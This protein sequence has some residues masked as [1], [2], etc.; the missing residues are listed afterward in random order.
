MEIDSIFISVVWIKAEFGG[1]SH[2][3]IIG[4]RPIIRFQHYVEDWLSIAKD[5]EVVELHLDKISWEGTAKLKFTVKPKNNM[6]GLKVG[7][8]IELLMRIV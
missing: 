8:L 2:A 5:V 4:L 1:R 7:E 6:R 3:P